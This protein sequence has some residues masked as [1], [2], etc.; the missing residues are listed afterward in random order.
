MN[1]RLDTHTRQ[2]NLCNNRKG[3]K[4]KRNTE[5]NILVNDYN[6]K[7]TYNLNTIILS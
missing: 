1:M 4:D 6:I 2:N 7:A 5:R 3:Q